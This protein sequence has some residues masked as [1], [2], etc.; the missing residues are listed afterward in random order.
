MILD[1]QRD[2]AVPSMRR[3][4]IIIEKKNVFQTLV[5]DLKFFDKYIEVLY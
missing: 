2:T 3:I 4:L 5:I 1:Q